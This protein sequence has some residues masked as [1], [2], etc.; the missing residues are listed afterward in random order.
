DPRPARP[1]AA[2]L[3]APG[4]RGRRAGQPTRRRAAPGG[5]EQGTSRTVTSRALERAAELTTEPLATANYL[6]AAARHA[7][8]GGEPH[9]ARLLLRKVRGHHA[10][11][12]SAQTELLLGE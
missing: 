2:P 1:P 9:R 4:R 7:W 5:Q 6:V 8:E 3:P 11:H 12:V 10:P